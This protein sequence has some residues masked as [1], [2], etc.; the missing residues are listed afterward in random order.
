[1]ATSFTPFVDGSVPKAA[2]FN[3][4][5]QSALSNA[6]ATAADRSQTG[7][8]RL[9][10]GL[11]RTAANDSATVALNSLTTFKGSFYGALATDP[12]LDPL[13]AAIGAGDMYYNTALQYVKVYSGT[14][15]ERPAFETA[16]I[17]Q[18]NAA[19]AAVETAKSAGLA[20][21]AADVSAVDA[22]RVS[23]QALML[24]DVNEVTARK[25]QAL[26]VDIP[27]AIAT[28]AAINNRGA[29]AATTAYALKD[30][31]LTGGVWYMCVVAHTSST[32]FA[33]DTASKWR[34]Y[35]GVTSG[36]LAA[37]YSNITEQSGA[38]NVGVRNSTADQYLEEN[39]TRPLAYKVGPFLRQIKSKACRILMTGTSIASF[40]QSAIQ[41]LGAM[42][43]NRYGKNGSAINNMGSFGGNYA[44]QAGHKKQP[45][46]GPSFNRMAFGPGEADISYTGLVDSINVVYG[47][48]SDGGSFEV[49]IDDV[50]DAT[51]TSS[52]TQVYEQ[53]YTK[54]FAS[55]SLRKITIKAPAVDWAYLERVEMMQ[56]D[57]GVYVENA[58][59]GGSGLLNAYTLLGTDAANKPGIAIV[60]NNGIDAFC[61]RTGVTKPD[62]IICQHFTNDGDLAL[63]TAG[64]T[65]L[66]SQTKALGIPLVLISEMPALNAVSDGVVGEGLPGTLKTGRLAILNSLL[67]YRN[68][69]HVTVIDWTEMVDYSIKSAYEAKY[70]PTADKTH[71]TVEGHSLLMAALC[72]LFGL[73]NPAAQQAAAV[74][75]DFYLADYAAVMPYPALTDDVY[76]AR[77]QRPAA[78]GVLRGDPLHAADTIIIGK[79]LSITGAS[80][81]VHYS[82]SVPNF[83]PLAA[84]DTI[85][86][87]A[88]KD[89]YGAYLATSSGGTSIGSVRLMHGAGTSN[90][91]TVLVL[92]RGNA[93]APATIGLLNSGNNFQAQMII[94]GAASV[95]FASLPSPS[96]KAPTYFAL[97]YRHSASDSPLAALAMSIKNMDV[98][99]LWIVAGSVPVVT[100]RFL[101]TYRQVGFPLFVVGDPTPDLVTPRQT[102][103]ETINGGTV[104]KVALDTVVWKPLQGA[105]A[106]AYE[107]RNKGALFAE[108]MP[109]TTPG[110]QTYDGKIGGLA[111]ASGAGFVR[112]FPIVTFPYGKTFT[113]G[114]RGPGGT[115]FL[116]YFYNGGTNA[117]TYLKADG[118]WETTATQQNLVVGSN[119]ADRLNLGF[120]FVMPDTSFSVA[121]GN[122]PQMKFLTTTG[123]TKW[124]DA[125]LCE[126]SSACVSAASAMDTGPEK[127]TGTAAPTS[128][129]YAKG[130]IRYNS[131]P[132]ASG[133]V[134]WVCTTAGIAGSTAVFK[135]FGAISA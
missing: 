117:Y 3:Q 61:G 112:Y 69:K 104:E 49:Y 110:A 123:G 26:A 131:A 46:G 99:G 120:T 19:A 38:K 27:N 129:Y 59:L 90:D 23:S 108:R 98:F 45:Y 32:D 128:G 30:I 52:G 77:Y 58:T 13:G 57:A 119:F 54:T 60:G 7:L 75:G 118:S 83:L 91:F 25:L 95:A 100:P 97:T 28:V 68:E 50:L 122:N 135:T 101:D 79:A 10:T 17:A 133:T 103:L 93:L 12:T 39:D 89:A 74:R 106:R 127:D 94:E 24:N 65:R 53:V 36:D 102:Y 86:N 56:N 70:F 111:A 63:F 82:Q 107:M 9:Q 78:P 14:T 87:S 37:P 22:S 8:D 31:V 2:D 42:L 1:M 72:P 132:S 15:W 44:P 5:G 76:S 34:V 71:P 47:K 85:R 84:F 18:I 6:N 40:D 11:D 81:A 4:L 64:V 134:G 80:A 88:T 55:R 109:V 66:V 105:F 43:Q 29:W 51:L 73:P 124:T 121:L 21:M 92:G 113:L 41:V 116:L 16:A 126:G 62:L 125:F 115:A 96:I 67:A 114:L 20:D 33:A 130:F 35:Q 48:E